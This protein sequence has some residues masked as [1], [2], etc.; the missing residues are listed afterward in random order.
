VIAAGSGLPRA[1]NLVAC[2]TLCAGLPQV[3][4]AQPGTSSSPERLF[5][6]IASVLQH[7]RCLNCHM[8]E[9]PFQ[10]DIQIPH[11]QMVV[12][13]PN[14]TG[15]AGLQC[16]A[17]HQNENT[18]DGKVPGAPHWH[19]APLLMA[20]QGLSRDQ[21][22]RQLKD[23]A[24]NG[25]R[26]GR[27]QVIEHMRRDPLVLWA[28]N[29]GA[30]RTTPKLT[31]PSFWNALKC[32][33][34][35]ACPAQTD[36]SRE[37]PIHFFVRRRERMPSTDSRSLDTMKRN[38]SAATMRARRTSRRSPLATEG[39]SPPSESRLDSYRFSSCASMGRFTNK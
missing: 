19:L 8:I 34:R 5:D 36:P 11:A 28:S 21:I 13:G 1:V 27:E 35:P 25:N 10:T 24:R 6:P 33:R 30:G 2:L 23:P 3:S 29:P 17:C 9:G 22:C 32:G 12:R 15:S 16:A 20:W 7:P 38:V 39:T 26:K 4:A 18:V 31:I 37:S 14:G